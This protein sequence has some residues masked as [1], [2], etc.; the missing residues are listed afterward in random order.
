[1]NV[2]FQ[3]QKS[4]CRR[5]PVRNSA[6]R[7]CTIQASILNQVFS[8]LWSSVVVVSLFKQA[9]FCGYLLSVI[10][11]SCSVVCCMSDLPE[12]QLVFGGV[13]PVQFQ[14]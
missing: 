12:G 1:M 3:C 5:I 10:S 8:F 7:W 13:P 4:T 6:Q 9:P 11:A 14:Q 2:R